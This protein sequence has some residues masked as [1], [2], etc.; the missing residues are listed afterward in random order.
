[1]IIQS[2][3][4][5]FESARDVHRAGLEIYHLQCTRRQYGDEPVLAHLRADFRRK[6]G[7]SP[8]DASIRAGQ[9]LNDIDRLIERQFD[10]KGMRSGIAN[11]EVSKTAQASDEF[12]LA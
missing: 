5:T 4:N 12:E 1:M 11:S 10:F 7:L 3:L 9:F 6:E 2:P 8:S